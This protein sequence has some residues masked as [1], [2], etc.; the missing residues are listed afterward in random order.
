MSTNTMSPH[1]QHCG[2]DL[3]DGDIFDR[4]RAKYPDKD[5]ASIEEAARCYGWTPRERKRFSRAII[6]QPLDGGQY[7]KCPDCDERLGRF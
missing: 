1:C 4:L 2:A 5:D 6:F 3:D 7:M